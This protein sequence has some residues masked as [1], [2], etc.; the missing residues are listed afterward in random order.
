[1]DLQKIL[2][3]VPD[4]YTLKA[5]LYPGLLVTLPLIL[6]I[7]VLFPTGVP[8]GKI[9]VSLFALCG[10]SM[11]FAQMGRDLGKRKEPW[12]FASWGGIPTTRML[13]HRQAPNRELLLARH[14]M[15]EQLLPGQRM[16]TDEE[17]RKDP[18][19]ADDIY[20]TCIARLIERTRDK[21]K[22]R[23]LFDENC[24]YGFRRNLWGMKRLGIVTTGLGIVGIAAAGVADWVAT[25]REVSPSLFLYGAVLVVLLAVWLVW[26]TPG[27]VRIPG[28]AYALRL[29]GA[30]ETLTADSRDARP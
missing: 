4:E 6:L 22:F 1:M 7:V 3:H 29:L 19:R 10:G 16:P 12:L 17:E 23:L 8:G 21:K 28:E 20:A 14:R 24:N 18:A 13:R 5:R 11:L 2:G 9:F 30:T 15:L 25:D 27:W 26:V